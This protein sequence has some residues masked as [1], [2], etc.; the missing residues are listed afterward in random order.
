MKLLPKVFAS[1]AEWLARFQREAQ[2][3]AALNHSHIAQIYGLE[4]TGASR[5]LV[6]ELV[7]GAT[8]EE[9]LK[10]GRIPVEQALADRPRHANAFYYQ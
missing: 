6:M 8:L 5:C 1:D 2:V 10:R 9:R 3:L 4:G 7:E